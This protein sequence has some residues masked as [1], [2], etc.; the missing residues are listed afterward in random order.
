MGWQDAPEVSAKSAWMQAPEIQPGA[1]P[2]FMDRAW[3]SPIGRAV[4]DAV[5]APISALET[6]LG[7]NYVPPGQQGGETLFSKH[8]GPLLTQDAANAEGRYQQALERNRNTPGYAAALQQAQATRAK[9]GP[10]GFGDQVSAPF[11]PAATGLVGLVTGGFDQAN[12]NADE[13][14]QSQNAYASQHP[15]L[16]TGAGVI[17]GL[18]TGAPTDALTTMAT[19]P[20]PQAINNPALRPMAKEAMDAGYVLPPRMA[21]EKPGVVSNALQG[22]AGKV[23]TAQGAS[24]ANQE[25]TNTLAKQAIGLKPD[26]EITDQALRT[27]RSQAGQ[28]KKNIIQSVPALST[29]PQYAQ[30][31]ANLSGVRQSLAQQFPNIAKNKGIE[32][33]TT[34]LSN[35]S[36]FSTQDAFDLVQ[37]LRQQASANY[38]AFDDAD[39][40]ALAGAQKAAADSVEDLIER[41]LQRNGYSAI[42]D[43][44]DSRQ[45]MAKTYDVEAATN[46]NT[47]NVNA[48]KLAAMANKGRPLSGDL[49][50][51]AKVQSSF[52]QAMQPLDRFGGVE[53]LSTLD[54]GAAALSAAH[55][56]GGVAAAILG[57]PMARSAVLSK[58]VQAALARGTLPK[59]A[60]P[61][62]SGLPLSA[63]F[64]LPRLQGNQ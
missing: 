43:F 57:K 23:K 51:I 18:A 42:Q 31:V 60:T 19:R 7:S 63:A 28:V 15:I 56:K 10:S 8:V 47:G 30:E 36:H 27:I 44:R 38:K 17:G 62:P 54:M 61:L 49:S 40:I 55:G 52:P 3:A 32:E 37:R 29:D 48:A 33:L 5:L 41:N 14:A 21:S 53:P 24:E 39:K 25:V 12:A 59:L 16:S 22:W 13:Q 46:L 1:Q 45:L 64:I 9:I 58:P 34:D 6:G 4:H 35:A 50:T 20:I 11:N 26:E 2:S